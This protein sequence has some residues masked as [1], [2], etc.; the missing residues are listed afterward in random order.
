MRPNI[1][2]KENLDKSVALK[3]IFASKKWGFITEGCLSSVC[4]YWFFCRGVLIFLNKRA[5]FIKHDTLCMLLWILEGLTESAFLSQS[6]CGDVAKE[7]GM[8]N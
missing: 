6:L 5:S 3:I 8:K 1:V 7:Q 4:L 2:C